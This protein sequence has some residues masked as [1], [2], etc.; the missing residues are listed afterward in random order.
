MISIGLTVAT[1]LFKTIYYILYREAAIL[2]FK[3]YENKK[4]IL[5]SI[6]YSSINILTVRL[7]VRQKKIKLNFLHLQRN[8]HLYILKMYIVMIFSLPMYIV[9]SIVLVR[10]KIIFFLFFSLDNTI[11]LK[12]QKCFRID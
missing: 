6:D 1:Y 5:L 3:L 7:S 4:Y 12:P 8:L 10:I 11:W 2:K 9:Y